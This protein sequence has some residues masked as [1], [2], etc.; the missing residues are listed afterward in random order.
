MLA[1]VKDRPTRIVWSP[2]FN[3]Q[4]QWASEDYQNRGTQTGYYDY[5]AKDGEITGLSSGDFNLVFQESAIY[6]LEYI[7]LPSV[8]SSQAISTNRGCAAPRSIVSIGQSVFFLA[9]DGFCVSN[10]ADVQVLS[11]GRVWEYFQAQNQ[12]AEFSLV[13]GVADTH[14]NSIIWNYT[15]RAG[16][17]AQLIYNYAFD[18][19][20]HSTIQGDWIFE[21]LPRRITM[22]DDDPD[23]QNDGDMSAEGLPSFDDNKFKTQRTRVLSLWVNPATDG[24]VAEYRQ[25]KGS[26]LTATFQTG[27]IQIEAGFLSFIREVMPH[28]DAN[29]KCIVA[30]IT[31]KITLGGDAKTTDEVMQGEQG[32]ISVINEGRYHSLLIKVPEGVSW[33]TA[34]GFS[35][36]YEK[37]GRV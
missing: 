31:G 29:E 32:F 35:A 34:W 11:H 19:W 22:S 17:K 30:S 28:I 2:Y 20:T 1:N 3:A 10:G 9:H 27:D 24:G 16:T 25:L 4:G 23:F 5:E 6:R 15:T 26:P 7:G 33:R 14:S 8:F 21:G 13:Q 37:A 18:R 36:D 12:P